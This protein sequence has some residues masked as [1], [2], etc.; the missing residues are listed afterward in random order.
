MKNLVTWIVIAVLWIN[1]SY[2]KIMN[3]YEPEIEGVYSSLGRLNAIL[4]DPDVRLNIFE[5]TAIDSK[6]N[7]LLER[8]LY[9]E[10]TQQLLTQF[11]FISPELYAAVDSIRSLTGEAVIVYVKF[12]P[13]TSMRHQAQGTTNI[14]QCEVNEHTYWSEFGPNTVS[15]KI[16]SLIKAMHLLAHEFGHVLY[17]VPNLARYIEF[18]EETYLTESFKSNY[19]GHNDNDP[20]GRTALKC[21]RQFKQD[22]LS[23]LR[24]R[25]AHRQ[26][27]LALVQYLQ[28]AMGVRAAVR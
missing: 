26:N 20:S 22:Y 6:I 17:Q 19:I 27:T 23:Y 21:E 12:V 5:R 11:R 8:I 4:L 3:G 7:Q 28:K 10:L 25:G 18:Y 9:Y 1:P 14:A 15:V 24:A 13:T 2:A 16:A